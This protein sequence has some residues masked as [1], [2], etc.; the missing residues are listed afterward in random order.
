MFFFF[1]IFN[2]SKQIWFLISE[3]YNSVGDVEPILRL[4]PGGHKYH[5]AIL[6]GFV[7][8]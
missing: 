2:F 7:V 8:P 5:V 3:A 4:N 1:I 6:P